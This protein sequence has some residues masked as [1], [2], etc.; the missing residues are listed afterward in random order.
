MT[1]F[2]VT[3]V[4]G[5]MRARVWFVW[6]YTRCTSRM[7]GVREALESDNNAKPK[8]AGALRLTQNKEREPTKKKVG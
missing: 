4:S 8:Y 5:Y 3:R 6:F 1:Y 2:N 7:Q